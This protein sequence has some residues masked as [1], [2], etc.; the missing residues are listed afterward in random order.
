MANPPLLPKGFSCFQGRAAFNLRRMSF[1]FDQRFG[2]I[3]RLYGRQGLERLAAAHVAVVGVGGVGSWVVEALARS[4]IGRLTLIDLDDVC[5]TNI[6]RQLPALTDTVGRPKVSVLAERVAAINPE[7][8]VKA[9]QEFFLESSADRLLAADYD[10]VVDAIDRMAVK[11]LLIARAVE[12]GMGVVTIGGAGGRRDPSQVRCGD[13]G[14]SGGDRLLKQVRRCLRQ[15]FGWAGGAP[16]KRMEYGVMAVYSAEPQ[17]YPRPDGTVC[18]VKEEEGAMRMDCA[19]GYG[20]ATFVTGTFGF[21]A[22]A[23]V[24]RQIAV[25]GRLRM[26]TAAG[27]L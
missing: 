7:C 24:V 21:V 15:E 6:N 26:Q 13:L 10:W 25:N 16:G 5:V 11:A 20:S 27:N 2:G 19:S 18:E 9:H 12:R 8:T 4:G 3:A 22:A 14:Q 17:V 1:E 23:E